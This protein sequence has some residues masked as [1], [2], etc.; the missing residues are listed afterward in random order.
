MYVSRSVDAVDT[1][2]TNRHLVCNGG[3]EE[4]VSKR[5]MLSGP[6][7]AEGQQEWPRWPKGL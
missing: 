6:L 1:S 3:K 7:G 5:D 4:R 2:E